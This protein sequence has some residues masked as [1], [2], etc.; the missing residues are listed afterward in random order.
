MDPAQQKRT[1][2]EAVRSEYSW[3]SAQSADSNRRPGEEAVGPLVW[4]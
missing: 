3:L 1:A 4:P 2:A